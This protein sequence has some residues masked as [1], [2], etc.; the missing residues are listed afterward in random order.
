MSITAKLGEPRTIQ[1]P[2]GRIAYRERGDG[3]PIVFVHG[4]GV[5]GDL[6]RKVAPELARAYR[7]I[8]PDWPLGAHCERV[9]P[10]TDMSLPGLATIVAEFLAALDLSEVTI[11]SNDTGGAISQSLVGRRGE[12]VERLVLTS[13]DAFDKYPPAPQRLLAAAAHA[14]PLIW[15]LGK[16]MRWGWA[17]RL[18]VAYGWT[19]RRPIESRIMDAYTAGVRGRSWVRRDLVRILRA[20]N[21]DDMFAAAIGLRAFDRPALVVWAAD[22]RLFPPVYGRLLA[23]LLPQG[24]FVEL[25]DCMT[26]VPEEQPARLVELIARFLD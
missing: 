7:C 10:A 19:T 21:R 20:A 2:S 8:V 25:P 3:R 16:A 15:V 14:P 11:V 5:T 1:T 9:H 23:E 26:F 17:Q 6:W 18:P 4:V 22:D 12:R 24:R 13:C